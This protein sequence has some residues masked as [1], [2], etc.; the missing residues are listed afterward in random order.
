MKETAKHKRIYEEWYKQNRDTDKTVAEIGK[1]NRATVFRYVNEFAWHDRADRRDRKAAEIAGR[2]A[3]RTQ[4]QLLIEH[5]AEAKE[6][7]DIAL[8]A[9]RDVAMDRPADAISAFFKA[10]ELERKSAGLPDY[11]LEIAT[12]SNEDINRRYAEC[13]S[14]IGGIGSGAEAQERTDTESGVDD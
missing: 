10:T 2:K 14:R 4:A 12:L 6:I 3:E 13:I 7:K 9:L 1:V 5:Q 11:L 8:K